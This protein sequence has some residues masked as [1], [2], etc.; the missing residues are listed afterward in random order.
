MTIS[1]RQ[2]SPITSSYPI[3]GNLVTNYEKKKTKT[4]AYADEFKEKE[5]LKKEEEKYKKKKE[6][7]SYKQDR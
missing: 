5:I 4:Q 6:I 7:Y 2:Q 1:P 3:R